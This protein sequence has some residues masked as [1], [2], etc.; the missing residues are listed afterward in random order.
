MAISQV[1]AMKVNGTLY[2]TLPPNVKGS[3]AGGN[4]GSAAKITNTSKLDGVAVSR[5]DAGVFGSTVVD[6]N[7][8]EK[9]LGSGTL[10][11]NNEKPIATRLSTKLNGTEDAPLLLSACS[12]AN[13][14]E[15]IHFIKVCTMGCSEGVRTRQL[16]SAI[17]QGKFNRYTGE[18]E[19]GYPVVQADMFAQDIAARPSREYPGRLSYKSTALVPTNVDYK[20]KTG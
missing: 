2:N 6:T 15:S 8:I 9:S 13:L 11:Y 16:T 5:Y 7:N 4:G 1:V 12:A 18:F 17:R 19:V 20:P 14:V 10:A 3:G